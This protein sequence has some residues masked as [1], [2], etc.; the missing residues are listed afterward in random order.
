[1]TPY[2]N[3]DCP[4]RGK[5]VWTTCPELLRSYAPTRIKPVTSRSKVWCLSLCH[6]ATLFTFWDWAWVYLKDGWWSCPLIPFYVSIFIRLFSCITTLLRHNHILITLQTSTHK[7]TYTYA[8]WQINWCCLNRNPAYTLEVR[9]YN[10][11]H[12][13]VLYLC[14]FHMLFDVLANELQGDQ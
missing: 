8:S 7:C 2:S 6:H 14:F 12:F 13:K 11:G 5:W 10:L 3:E 9:G 4:R 1:M